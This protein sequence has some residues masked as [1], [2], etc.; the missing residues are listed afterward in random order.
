MHVCIMYLI[1]MN[2][3]CADTCTCI[4]KYACGVH[5]FMYCLMCTCIDMCI[6]KCMYAGIIITHVC[7]YCAHVY[8]CHKHVLCTCAQVFNM[9][10]LNICMYWARVNIIVHMHV[11]MC[12]C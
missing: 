9:H 5:V 3:A 4:V 8:A 2:C 11:Y 10:V 1:C 7:M 6:L 12:K